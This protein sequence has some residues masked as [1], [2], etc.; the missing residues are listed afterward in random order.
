M[1]RHILALRTASALCAIPAVLALL[2]FGGWVLF[3]GACAFLALAT[4]EYAHMARC[5]D[6]RPLWAASLLASVLLCTA[7]VW[8]QLRPWTAFGLIAC[9][10]GAFAWRGVFAR[11]RGTADL[12][13]TLAMPLYVGGAFA[14]ML[15][16]RGFG[17]PHI[18]LQ[19][20]AFSLPQGMWWMLVILAG[21][22][23]FDTGAYLI[24]RKLGKH[25]MAPVI[26]P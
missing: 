12:V 22:W 13:A 3:L 8:P 7:S 4:Y 21:T 11:P 14:C 9:M 10:T 2:W 1:K 23:M 16:I 18:A 26:S 5:K 24:G 20:F 15:S 19:P 17:V 6:V 25:K